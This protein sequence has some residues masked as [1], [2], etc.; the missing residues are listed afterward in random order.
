MKDI[1]IYRLC[2]D[3][4]T[5]FQLQDEEKKYQLPKS[6]YLTN[7]DLFSF[8]NKIIEEETDDYVLLCHDDVVLPENIAE[9]AESAVTSANLSFGEQNWGV[10]GNAGIEVISKRAVTYLSDP[11]TEM[12]PPA[13]TTPMIA[14][15]IDGNI[16]LLNL[17]NIRKNKIHFPP[18]L[19][20]F[21]LYDLILCMESYKKG[22]ICG[23]TSDLYVL[24]K[25]PGSYEG[26][27]EGTK[28]KEIQ[29][30]LRESFTNHAITSINDLIQ[31]ERDYKY[32][33]EPTNLK[34]Y[35]Q[36][37]FSTVSSIFEK[38]NLELNILIRIHKKTKKLHRLLESVS[39]FN[40]KK[41]ENLKLNILLGVNNV[42]EKD[43]LEFIEHIAGNFPTL[44]IQTVDVKLQGEQYPRVET[45]SFLLDQIETRE[46]SYVWIVDYD[47][48]IMP[49]SAKYLPIILSNDDLVIGDSYIFHETWGKKNYPTSSHLQDRISGENVKNI[50]SGKNFIPICSIIYPTKIIKNTFKKTKLKG[51]YFEDY[52]ILLGSLRQNVRWY[53]IPLAGISYHGSNTV[54]EEDRTHWEY[55]YATFLTEIINNKRLVPTACYEFRR[56]IETSELVEFRSFKKGLLW[57]TLEKYRR[58]KEKAKELIKGR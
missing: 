41:S 26:F 20:G 27:L 21:H 40:S 49:E 42:H 48:Y 15:S 7:M 51:D 1:K 39:I 29:R 34:S 12:L 56:D 58:I 10:L 13:T 53:P 17:K 31:I 28:D 52:A 43:T 32:L 2:R 45:L 6:T 5:I 18:Q 46:N 33:T 23:I 30:Y 57:R 4:K 22:L 14:E 25:S 35:E 16:M 55:S 3:Q 11:H 19:Q 47:D 38:K 54:L 24:H 9:K 44:N 50:L 8:I 36:K 37:V